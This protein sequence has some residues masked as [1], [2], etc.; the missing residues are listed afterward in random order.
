MDFF[1][2]KT[3][4]EFQRKFSEKFGDVEI[5]SEDHRKDLSKFERLLESMS[6]SKKTPEDSAAIISLKGALDSFQ[7]YLNKNRL[8]LTESENRSLSVITGSGHPPAVKT[9]MA[10]DLIHDIKKRYETEIRARRDKEQFEAEVIALEKKAGLFSGWINLF[11]FSMEYGTI[12]PFTHRLK[13]KSLELLKVKCAGWQAELEAGVKPILDNEYYRLSIADYNTL[14]LILNLREG[15]EALS[16]VPANLYY[17][18]ESIEDEIGTFAKKYIPVLINASTIE[19]AIK[20]ISVDGKAPHGFLGTFRDMIGQP[21]FNNRPIVLSEYEKFNRTPLGALMSYYTTLVAKPVTS[22]NLVIYI[23]GEYGEINRDEKQ[24]T[25]EASAIEER[26]KHRD[27]KEVNSVSRRYSEV[28]RIVSVLLPRGREIETGLRAAD[29]KLR[30]TE[31]AAQT[32]KPFARLYEMTDHFIRFFAEPV[33]NENEFQVEYDGKLYKNYFD[34]RP[35]LLSHASRITLE[36]LDLA[37]TRIKEVLNIQISRDKDV[38]GYL[39]TLFVLDSH[40]SLFSPQENSAREIFGNVSQKIYQFA[41]MLNDLI[42][43]YNDNRGVNNSDAR[44]NY[45]F[46]VN[47]TLGGLKVLRNSRLFAGNESTL[48]NFLETA[49]AFAYHIAY[50]LRNA[51][52]RAYVTEMANLK[53]K[54]EEMQNTPEPATSV[55]QPAGNYGRFMTGSDLDSSVADSLDALYQDNLS[56][57]LK[58]EYFEDQVMSKFYD[59]RGRYKLKAERFV[60]YISIDGFKEINLLH[61]H[62][63]GDKLLTAAAGILKALVSGPGKDRSNLL[64]RY[65]GADMLGYM[66][67]VTISS[68]LDELKHASASFSVSMQSSSPAV[69][70]PASLSIGVYQERNGSPALE[71]I[72]IVRGLMLKARRNGAGSICFI[73]DSSRVLSRRDLSASGEPLDDLVSYLL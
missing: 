15:V 44:L 38:D 2:D 8:T 6:E 41:G 26:M 30:Q 55:Q 73:K 31:S 25:P 62:G 12:T 70:E 28:E 68:L 45:D 48:I 58:R 21:I 14:K 52:A 37:G 36:E 42:L 46:C 66:H 43:F 34:V 53:K 54:I 23:T 20:R 64:I 57:L 33:N 10:E 51:Y 72:G 27:R 3:K 19:T 17:Y 16:R 18:P 1:Q 61:G 22:M 32:H 9:R 39:E 50:E 60:F 5:F 56:G 7:S 13:Y 40:R 49:C 67:S 65:D 24:L 59:S 71:N 35:E 11:K 63:A 47:G 69:T 29:P 4:D